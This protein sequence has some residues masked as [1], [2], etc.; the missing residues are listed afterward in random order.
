M[1]RFDAQ[2]DAQVLGQVGS[3]GERLGAVG[4]LVR[5]SLRVGLGVNLH[6]RLGEEG[7]R[8]YFASWG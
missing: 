3:V 1:V 5:F 6:I 4:T 7:E 8:A 2:V